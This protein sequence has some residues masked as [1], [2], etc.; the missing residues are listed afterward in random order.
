MSERARRVHWLRAVQL[1]C[2]QRRII[3]VCPLICWRVWYMCRCCE[4]P[5][6]YGCYVMC[7]H[8]VYLQVNTG[9][10]S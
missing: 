10:K 6:F 5:L 8:M 3:Q 2:C 9:I 4:L 1:L 7:L